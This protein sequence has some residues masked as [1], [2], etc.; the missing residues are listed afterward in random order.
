M[1]GS[2]RGADLAPKSAKK[3][4]NGVIM[5]Q[6]A[7]IV[8]KSVEIHGLGPKSGPQTRQIP[9]HGGIDAQSGDQA[10]RADLAGQILPGSEVVTAFLVQGDIQ[11]LG[12]FFFA[13]P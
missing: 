13:D 11:A 10:R 12:F 8:W 1:D 6:S 7:S 9:C 5:R 2:Q 3:P 4:L